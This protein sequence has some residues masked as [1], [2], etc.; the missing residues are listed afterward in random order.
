MVGAVV[1]QRGRVVGE[2]WHA[3]AGEAHA[4]RR[5]LAEAGEATRGA[6][7]FVTLE[8]CA[9]HGRTPP[10]T[11]AV[12]A[13]GVARV[14]ACH[15]DPDPRVRGRGFAQLAAAGIEVEV[16][17]RLEEAVRLN[18][19][20]L[21]PKLLGR[22][23]VTL[24]WAMSL[25]GRIA[26]VAGESQWLTSARARRHALVLREEHDAILVGSG[27][28]LADDPRLT[29]RLGF[30]A[31]PHLRGVLDRRLRL[32]A[33]ARLFREPGP[34]LVFTENDD[35][36]RRRQLEE[37]G[38]EVVCLPQVTPAAVLAVLA[39]R[40]VASVLL[41]GGG[42][43]AAAFAA[44]GC[45]DRVEA[46]IAPLLLGGR[47]APGPLGGPGLGPLAGAPRL[48]ATALRRLGP[49]LLLTGFRPGCLPDLYANVAG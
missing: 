46:L 48:E 21:V 49:D 36:Q 10:C 20:Y 23:A 18:W 28:A 30:A 3:R 34:V 45:Y 15:L 19:R 7:L 25:D 42:E 16:G 22:P 27:T 2:G 35:R 40:E 12:I 44:A 5:A 6:T 26:T 39:R 13:A 14:V 38:A 33:A 8:P 37:A 29:R 9:H 1:V 31:R 41:E 47:E 24:K 4:E 11:E 43:V 32:S 17:L